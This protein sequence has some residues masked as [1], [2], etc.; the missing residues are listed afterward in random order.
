[1]KPILLAVAFSL[2]AACA[3]APPPD[4]PPAPADAPL[5]PSPPEPSSRSA[6]PSEEARLRACPALADMEVDSGR[7][8]TMIGCLDGL[9]VALERDAPW[10][11]GS[12]RFELR[13]DGDLVTCEGVL[14][15]GPCGEAGV[16]C[17]DPEVAVSTTGCAR[18]PA[19][20]GFPDVT[21][22]AHLPA[23]VEITVERDG[24]PLASGRFTPTYRASQPNGPG[25][26]PLC[27]QA[28]EELAVS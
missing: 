4:P 23:T 14:P 22:G 12:Y 7:I 21:F 16:T 24:T 20:H 13:L 19:E 28:S 1:M 6:T 8:C 10:P 26:A 25:C 9:R 5:P 18:P 15:L 2:A 17:S 11:A 3:P 27:C